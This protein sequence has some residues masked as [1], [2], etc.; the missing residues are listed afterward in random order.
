MC[1]TWMA[2]PI[3]FIEESRH[4]ICIEKRGCVD[5]PVDLPIDPQESQL[6]TKSPRHSM[7]ALPVAPIEVESS[8]LRV[9]RLGVSR[10]TSL[11]LTCEI[12]LGALTN[13]RV[14]SY[15]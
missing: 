9:I 10:G 6:S 11:R 13:L 3:R 2:R 15:A 8:G 5:E 7:S 12:L 14:R 1:P 4:Q